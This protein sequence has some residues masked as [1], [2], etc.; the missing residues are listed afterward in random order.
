LGRKP[1]ISKIQKCASQRLPKTLLRP[2]NHDKISILKTVIQTRPF[3]K[4]PIFP[5]FGPILGKITKNV[6]TLLT[7]I[8]ETAH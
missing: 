1:K 4:R 7:H 5:R 8:S 2:K 6:R 3:R